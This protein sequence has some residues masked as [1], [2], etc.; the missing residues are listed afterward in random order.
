MLRNAVAAL[1]LALA[2]AGCASGT[3]PTPPP[4]R[5]D[6]P[7]PAEPDLG[8]T[9]Y[10][11]GEPPGFLPSI[12]DLPAEAQLENHP[13]AAALRK[14]IA[15]VGLDIDML[16]PAGYWLVHRDDNVAQYLARDPRGDDADFVY[17]SITKDGI[18]WRLGGWGGCR[19]EIVLDGLSLATW[20]LDPEVPPPGADATTFPAQVT[21]RTCTSGRAMGGRLQPPTI[22]YGPDSVVIVFAAIPLEAD[23]FNCP[24]N[25]ATPVVVQLREPLGERELLDGAFFPPAEPVVPE[26]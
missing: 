1:L 18:G 23:A 15:E 10:S 13:S 5:A 8:D 12:L 17:A 22:S 3:A 4:V 9:R 16:P 25:P 11:C 2:L 24:S 20:V 21:E 26:S 7:L 19:P 6:A 14:S